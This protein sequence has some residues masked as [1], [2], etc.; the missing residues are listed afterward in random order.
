MFALEYTQKSENW[1]RGR[2]RKDEGKRD[3]LQEVW[4]GRGDNGAGRV[5]LGG[6]GGQGRGGTERRGNAYKSIW[7]PTVA[8]SIF[9][10]A[11]GV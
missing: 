5:K 1:V 3:K 9:I 6:M 7:K 8:A 2:K 4:T 10:H 11:C